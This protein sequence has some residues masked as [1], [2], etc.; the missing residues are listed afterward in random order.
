MSVQLRSAIAAFH[1][2]YHSHAKIGRTERVHKR[3][4]PGVD[5]GHPERRRVQVFGDYFRVGQAHVEDEVERH[6]TDHIGDDDVGQC[7]ERFPLFV[8]PLLLR[9][10][11]VLWCLGLLFSLLVSMILRLSVVFLRRSRFGVISSGV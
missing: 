9:F 2:L 7:D 6:P 3:V 10:L 1:Q 5:V 8:R 4:Q 11:L